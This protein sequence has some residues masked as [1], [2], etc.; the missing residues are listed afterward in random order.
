MRIFLSPVSHSHLDDAVEI[1]ADCGHQCW[2]GPV[3]MQH[4]LAPFMKTSTVCLTCMAADPEMRKALREQTQKTGGLL[5]LPG[6][7]EELTKNVGAKV[8]EEIYEDFNVTEW[9]GTPL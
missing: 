2:I 4:V 7:R 5:G 1:T 9:D 8:A 6:A 3:S